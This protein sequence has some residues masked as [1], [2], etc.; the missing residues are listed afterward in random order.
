MHW[1]FEWYEFGIQSF[2]TLFVRPEIQNYYTLLLKSF[3]FLPLLG[4]PWL[5]L[6]LP[7]LLINVL[8]SHVE[9][10]SI[11][12]HYTAGL[13]PG[14]MIASV[15]GVH[16]L[17]R[18]VPYVAYIVLIGAL[19]VTLRVNYHHSPLPTTE[20]CWCAS[21]EVTEDDKRF[22]MV[23]QAIP[24]HATVTSSTELHAHVTHREFAY[25]LPHATQSAD[26]IALID[27]HRVIDNYGPKQY[28]RE[29]IKK[30]MKEK[31]YTLESQIGHFYL[32]KRNDSLLKTN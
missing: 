10:H 1:A 17:Q 5:V 11:K 19:A 2:R 21:Y 25:M 15:Y 4:V 3:G 29:L 8:S 6:S 13:V 26:Y 24:T 14:L 7:D 28:E 30:L 23:L 20:S 32:F 9:M 22:A 12:Y 16:Y 18:V 31:M 27:Q